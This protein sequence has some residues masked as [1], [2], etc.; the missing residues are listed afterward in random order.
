MLGAKPLVDQRVAILLDE[1]GIDYETDA[2]GDYQALLEIKADR[3]Q[4]V[5]IRSR[6]HTLD[7]LEVR[8]IYSVAYQT[9]Q[10]LSQQVANLLLG[11]NHSS[12]LGAWQLMESGGEYFAAYNA[13]VSADTDAQT[14]M[15]VLEAVVESADSIE[16]YLTGRDFF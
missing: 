3:F 16:D 7:E 12:K 15:T 11:I 4:Q 14:L 10:P 1:L 9:S 2:D 8:K 6:T 13:H 5:V